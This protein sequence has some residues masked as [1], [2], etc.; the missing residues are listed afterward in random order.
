MKDRI[1]RKTK[2]RY[3][4]RIRDVVI[5]GLGRPVLVY[6]Q[7]ATFECDN[8]YFDK[9]TNKSSG[10]CK[11]TLRESLQKQ[12]EYEGA[13]GQGIRYKYFVKG[14]C[15]VCKGKGFLETS[16]RTRIKCKVTWQPTSKS[17]DN[18][19]VFTSAGTEGSILVELKTHPKYYK[20][21][22]NCKKVVVDGVECVLA[23]LPVVRGLGNKSILVVHLFTSHK[24]PISKKER[25]KNYGRT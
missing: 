6:K 5:D 15:P 8:C 24:A 19:L 1:G 17:Y 14:R 2:E 16:R 12:R 10:K 11:W 4:N 18:A 13:G 21:F 23:S 3:R 25:L 20:L 22:E 7:P 9:F